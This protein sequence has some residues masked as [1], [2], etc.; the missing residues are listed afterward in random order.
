MHTDELAA[1]APSLTGD[2]SAGSVAALRAACLHVDEG[3]RAEEAYLEACGSQI[4][5][6]GS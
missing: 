5:V 3:L 2:D 6:C 4:E 1:L